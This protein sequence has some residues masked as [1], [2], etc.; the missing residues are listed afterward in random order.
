V[1]K[2]AQRFAVLD[3]AKKRRRLNRQSNSNNFRAASTMAVMDVESSGNADGGD[4]NLMHMLSGADNGG[5]LPPPLEATS[6]ASQKEELD[7]DDDDDAIKNPSTYLASL[8]ALK[9]GMD[10]HELEMLQKKNAEVDSTTRQKVGAMT[11]SIKQL[12]LEQP[13][14]IGSV[15]G[16]D[17][18]V[19]LAFN[20]WLCQFKPAILLDPLIAAD[21]D[22][23]A[24]RLMALKRNN[25]IWQSFVERWRLARIL[26]DDDF[27]LVFNTVKGGLSIKPAPAPQIPAESEQRTEQEQKEIVL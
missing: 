12:F 5:Q 18:Q 27:G 19:T 14:M 1:A 9:S 25:D 8:R 26:Y 17:H 24:R 22:G 2:A 11:D 15:P 6:L 16:L 20:L 3:N 10:Q 21:Y 23:F 13:G 4:V 7:V